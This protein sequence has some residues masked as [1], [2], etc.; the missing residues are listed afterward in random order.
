[1]IAAC[2]AQGFADAAHRVQ[3]I[4]VGKGAALFRRRRHDDEGDIAVCQRLFEGEGGGQPLLRLVRQFLQPR[5]QHRSAAAC[6]RYDKSGIAVD[7]DDVVPFA[8]QHRRQGRPAC[9]TRQR[10]AS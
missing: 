3:H 7:A 10:K 2:A 9:P 8:G 6:H 5:L 4:V 1:M